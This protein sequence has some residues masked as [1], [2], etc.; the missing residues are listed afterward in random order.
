MTCSLYNEVY[1]VYGKMHIG[2]LFFLFL[3]ISLLSIQNISAQSM[4]YTLHEGELDGAPFTVV[5]PDERVDGKVFFHVHGWRPADAPHKADIDP[6]EPFYRSLLERGWVIGRTAFQEN[7]VDHKAHTKALQELKVWI[8][9]NIDA[10][11]LVVLEGESTAG[12]LVLRIA[13]QNP[14]L[15]DGVIAKGAFIDLEDE[16]ADSYLQGNPSVPAILMSNLT[17]LDGPVSYAAVAENA[18]VSPALRP[19]MRP[20]HVNVNWVER[21]EAL[22]AIQSWI[23]E[24]VYSPVTDGTRSVPDRDTGTITENG[25]LVNKVT[26]VDIFFGNATLGFHPEELELAEIIQGETFIIEIGGQQ[27]NVYYGE[28]Y[29]DVS[30]GEWVAFPLADDQILLARNHESAIQSAGIQTGD[31]IRLWA[32]PESERH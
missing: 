8:E 24:G 15:A 17:E 2:I 3:I 12:T 28:T 25:V 6:D 9:E 14:D 10:A 1:S 5:V 16:A 19:L 26:A 18:P 29:G 31:E 27:R 4:N 22:Q 11:E 23:E 13:E 32:L 20:G 30:H 7:G 21:L